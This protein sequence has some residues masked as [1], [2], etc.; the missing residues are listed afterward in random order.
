M[1]LSCF[2][3][4]VGTVYGV[5]ISDGGGG[6]A[7]GNP[8]SQIYSSGDSQSGS[9]GRTQP[10]IL[11]KISCNDGWGNEFYYYSPPPYQGY[12][13]WS[14]GPNG[15]TFPPWFP[16]REIEDLKEKNMIRNWLSDDIVHMRN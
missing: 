5:K 8:P 2:N 14:A 7:V 9:D 13:L 1:L 10:Y 6:L 16:D 4:E 11:D 3:P 15:K 12:R